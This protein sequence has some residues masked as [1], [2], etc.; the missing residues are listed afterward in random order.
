MATSSNIEFPKSAYASAVSQ[1]KESNSPTFFAVPG[2]QGEPGPK[3]PKGDPGPKGEKGDPGQKGNPGKDGKSYIAPYG[4]GIGWALY[5]NKKTKT[6]PTGA[7]RGEDGWVSMYIDPE[8]IIEDFLPDGSVTL[9]S[10]DI[11]KINTRGLKLGAQLRIT[12]NIE[13]ITFNSNTEVWMKSQFLNLDDSISTFCANL[14]YQHNYEM[15]VTHDISIFTEAH[16]AAGIIPQ[17]RTDLDAAA[18]LKSIYI[19]VY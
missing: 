5:T 2:P 13:V 3:G 6:I 14:K 7:T 15:S 17:I 16:K 12:Y 1:S 4:Q 10:S 11:R 9:Y 18:K 19:S 8:N